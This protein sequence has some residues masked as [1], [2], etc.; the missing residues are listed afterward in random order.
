MPLLYHVTCLFLV[1]L[2]CISQAYGINLESESD[3]EKYEVKTTLE[4]SANV[5]AQCY[6]QSANCWILGQFY[7]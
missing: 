6:L 1:A 5:W 4:V 3:R 7:H 2:Q